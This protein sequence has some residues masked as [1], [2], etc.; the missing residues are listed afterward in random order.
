MFLDRLN[1]GNAPADRSAFSTIELSPSLE[2]RL[3]E[4]AIGGNLDAAGSA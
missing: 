3:D 4:A 1:T 2:D